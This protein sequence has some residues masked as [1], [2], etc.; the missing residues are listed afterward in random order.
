MAICTLSDM[1]HG[2][3]FFGLKDVLVGRTEEYYSRYY[4]VGLHPDRFGLFTQQHRPTFILDPEK[5]LGP[6]DP[7]TRGTLNF[8]WT[9]TTTTDDPWTLCADGRDGAAP[10]PPPPPTTAE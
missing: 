5:K 10:P 1:G 3:G 9:T 2:F 8:S 6:I 7:C 4:W